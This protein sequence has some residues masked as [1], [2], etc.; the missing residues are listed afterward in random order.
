MHSRPRLSPWP[1]EEKLQR[2]LPKRPLRKRLSASVDAV[3][4]GTALEEAGEVATEVGVEGA[5]ITSS[6]STK[7]A[8][9]DSTPSAIN[10]ATG[11]ERVDVIT[12]GDRVHSDSSASNPPLVNM[13]PSTVFGAE[14]DAVGATLDT[15]AK[16][17]SA[18]AREGIDRKEILSRRRTK[19][20]TMSWRENI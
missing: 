7:H 14:E 15:P 4:T 11:I 3:S 2:G 16:V 13:N 17:F 1:V 19:Y 18:E 5:P 9:F 6:E 12:T 10:T 8:S 20:Q